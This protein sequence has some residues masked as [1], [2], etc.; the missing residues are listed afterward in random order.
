MIMLT[1]KIYHQACD[2]LTRL[3]QA[4]RLGLLPLGVA[5]GVLCG[6]AHAAPDP[7]PIRPA[8][9]DSPMTNPPVFTWPSV[10]G[11]FNVEI[12][13]SNGERLV[14][15]T[16]R[17]WLTLNRSLPIG[18]YRWRWQG[19][20]SQ[21]TPWKNFYVGSNAV[22][23]PIPNADELWQR[24]NSRA[25]PRS[26]SVAAIRQQASPQVVAKLQHTLGIWQ[27]EELP[28]ELA[29]P[30]GTLSATRLNELF[31]ANRRLVF[32][33]EQRI[34]AAA[35]LWL[36]TGDVAALAEAKRRALHVASWDVNG[37]TSFAYHDQAGRSV[38]WML[39]LAY[40]WLNSHLT[41]DERQVLLEAI[42]PRL[43]GMVGT[44]SYG[45]DASRRLD[46]NPFN[47]HGVTAIAR[48]SLICAVLAGA[49]TVY[50]N[51]FKDVVP[52][53]L[54]WPIPWG[55]DQ[56]GYAA[57]T[58]YAHWQVLDNQLPVFIL[59][60][61][62]LS[63][64]LTRHPWMS[65]YGKYIANFLPP[66][67][68]SGLFGDETELAYTNVWATQAK[69]YAAALPS[70]LANWYARNQFGEDITHLT[71]LLSPAREWSAIPGHLPP[72]TPHAVHLP[73]IGWVAM[74]SDLGDRAR[75]SVYF[76][77]SPYGSFNHSHADQ[78]SFV[79]HARGRALAI[80]SGYY[81]YYGS[82]HW[83][84]WYKQTRAHNAVTFDG[85]QGQ[86][87]DTMKAKGRV[88][89]FEHNNDYVITTGDATVAYGGALTKAVRS[90]V[91]LRPNTLLVFD[92][93]ESATPRAWEWNLHALSRFSEQGGR[94]LVIEQDGV[95]LC[96]KMLAAPA[97]TFSQTDQ[98]TTP[99]QGS[100][101][102]QWHARYTTTT[103]STR[104]FFMALL[105]VDCAKSDITYSRSGEQHIVNIG[106]MRFSF[107]ES[108]Q[109]VK[110]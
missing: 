42:K 6:L 19:A 98:F 99:P 70:P 26:I 80:D 95:R 12:E 105:D 45:I 15:Q 106:G 109:V 23:L 47:S 18:Q 64:D 85:G 8:Q 3:P 13:S 5:L 28:A 107:S 57:G 17:N 74:H 61:Q 97:G 48:S 108:G 4:I 41:A 94:D 37:T 73:D 83:K 88:S 25:H 76:K 82:P 60:G 22:N 104:G 75:T 77:S 14:R 67:T 51:C 24:A 89:Y 46:S 103:K 87:H 58:S 90:M 11:P 78:N 59:L 100:S 52:R 29:V 81:D 1:R 86:L 50:D 72:G 31:T 79:I 32:K 101:P 27:A 39:A 43:M 91:Y 44:G 54:A 93:L 84:D 55:W 69:A 20:G 56:G 65:E 38:A 10:K 35:W 34:L 40:D 96:M 102:R 49:D 2:G 110:Q 53:Y 71:S 62:V 92:S 36:A 16:A 66:G 30:V 9:G 63:M 21:P 7:M 68:P 33:E